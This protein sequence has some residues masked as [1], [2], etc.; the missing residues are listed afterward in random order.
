MMEIKTLG[1]YRDRAPSPMPI[2]AGL[3]MSV[4]QAA[5]VVSQFA[6]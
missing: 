6:E 4:L 5:E 2:G 1:R 3:G